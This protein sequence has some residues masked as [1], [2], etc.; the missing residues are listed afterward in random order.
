MRSLEFSMT[1]GH[2]IASWA[3]RG[4]FIAKCECVNNQGSNGPF[5][6]NSL[7]PTDLSS[8]S[9]ES[10][11]NEIERL[12]CELGHLGVSGDENVDSRVQAEASDERVIN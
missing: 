4:R 1:Y 6:T 12:E 8:A 11:V 3:F 7:P 5:S 9:V 2:C 10:R